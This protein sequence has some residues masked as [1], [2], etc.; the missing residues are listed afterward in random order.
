MKRLMIAG[1]AAVALLGG[2]TGASAQSMYQ[3]NVYGSPYYG[4]H[5]YPGP[6]AER[7]VGLQVGPV[8]IYAQQPAYDYGYTY[9]P[10]WRGDARGS[11]YQSRA[12]RSQEWLPQ[13]PPGGGY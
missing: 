1:A 10:R 8:G 9:S 7:S 13:S 2:I 4:Y 11:T 12:F 3:D 6:Y 5:G